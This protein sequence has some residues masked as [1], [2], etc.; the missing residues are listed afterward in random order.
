MNG[1]AYR[2]FDIFISV[3]QE[4]EE[5]EPIAF[6]E[7]LSWVFI[8]KENAR[9]QARLEEQRQKYLQQQETL[10]QNQVSI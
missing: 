1:T 10:Y 9:L 2:L 3:P 6:E 5:K 4:E 7:K 8:E